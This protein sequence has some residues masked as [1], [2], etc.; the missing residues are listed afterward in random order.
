MAGCSSTVDSHLESSVLKEVLEQ[1][2]QDDAFSVDT[3]RANLAKLAA[4][5]ILKAQ[6][7]TGYNIFSQQLVEAIQ[8]LVE[9]VKAAGY[10]TFATT[11]SKLWRH[12]H[13]ARQ[14]GLK[15][16][17]NDLWLALGGNNEAFKKDPLLMQHCNTKLFEKV[18]KH[19]FP[20]RRNIITLENLSDDEE[21]A[22]RF[23]AGYVIRCM[24][25]KITKTHHSRKTM[26]L[27]ILNQ[28]KE[29]KDST[30]HDDISIIHTTM[31]REDK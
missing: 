11:E 18:I 31:A 22:L 25:K 5:F 12:F 6:Q 17:W 3:P 7:S 9:N 16:I 2:E 19:S 14:N 28:L 30:D 29:E 23:A 10:K 1:V 4:Q 8:K 21:N 15:D 26:M 20:V 24:H 13:E 27:V